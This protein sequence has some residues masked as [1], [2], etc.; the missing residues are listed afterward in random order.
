MY[1]EFSVPPLHSCILSL[2]CGE[3]ANTFVCVANGVKLGEISSTKSLVI[4]FVSTRRPLTYCKVQV[5]E[6][7]FKTRNCLY[8]E[9]DLV[10]DTPSDL[11]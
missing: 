1:S 10:S 8:D 11:I 6:T 3:C 5:R 9:M 4:L 7:N 2:R